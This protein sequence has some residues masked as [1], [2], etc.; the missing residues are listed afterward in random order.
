M[1]QIKNLPKKSHCDVKKT[2]SREGS[3]VYLVIQ[4]HKIAALRAA[5]TN[6][7]YCR[8]RGWLFAPILRH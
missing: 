5:E 4:Y 8:K 6:T 7:N 1:D 2:E 3:E